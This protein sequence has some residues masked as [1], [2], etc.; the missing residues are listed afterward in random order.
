MVWIHPNLALLKGR[1]VEMKSNGG[2]F[3]RGVSHRMIA[4]AILDEGQ[5]AIYK[6]E[7]TNMVDV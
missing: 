4:H 7:V 1:A 3:Q 5:L 2:C 6:N